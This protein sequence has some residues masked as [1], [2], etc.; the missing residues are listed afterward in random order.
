MFNEKYVMMHGRHI[1]D[2]N[3]ALAF[4]NGNAVPTDIDA[5]LYRSRRFISVM[6]EIELYAFPRITPEEAENIRRFLSKFTIVPLTKSI[7]LTTI[8][9]RCKNKALKI[10]D[11]AIAATAVVRRATLL[12]ND[13][14]L[15][16]L[17]WPGYTVQALLQS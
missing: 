6:T 3:A 7:K 4:L 5:A 12:T 17:K 16:N 11:A 1:L 15:L 14:K 13:E 9:I 2:T 10:P 8:A